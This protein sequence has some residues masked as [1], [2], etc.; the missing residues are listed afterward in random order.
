MDHPFLFSLL[1]DR[2]RL[3][4]RRVHLRRLYDV[5]H[6]SLQRHDMERARRAW[7][8]LARC[9]EVNWKTL[10]PLSVGL[11]DHQ[12]DTTESSPIKINYLRS[13]MLQHPEQ[14]RLS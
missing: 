1:E 9:N 5:L 4:S 8:I 10:W 11:L 14:V 7:A 3:T 2:P 6:L 13:M 12:D